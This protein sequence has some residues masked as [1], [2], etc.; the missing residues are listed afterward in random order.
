MGL[1]GWPRFGGRVVVQ[2][3]GPRAE[4]SRQPDLLG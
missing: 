2:S 4:S 3:T 1:K